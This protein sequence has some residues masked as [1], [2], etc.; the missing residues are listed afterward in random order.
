MQL[1]YATR[2]FEGFG[3]N[4]QYWTEYRSEGRRVFEVSCHRQITHEG[5]ER[6]E[7]YSELLE[8]TWLI[9]EYKP[10]G[11]EGE[12]KLNTTED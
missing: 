2:V 7:V 12:W 4:N 10:E 1:I 6:R 8:R 11:P 9:D 3:K 5:N